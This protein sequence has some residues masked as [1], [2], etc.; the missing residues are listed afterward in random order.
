MKPFLGQ[1]LILRDEKFGCIVHDTNKGLLYVLNQTGKDILSL[2]NGKNTTNE[3]LGKMKSM[4]SCNNEAIEDLKSFIQGIIDNEIVSITVSQKNIQAS[5]V[6]GIGLNV[7]ESFE[8]NPLAHTTLSAPIIIYW[9]VTGQCNLNCVHCYNNSSAELRKAELSTQ[10][11][12]KIIDDLAKQKV[13]WLAITGGEAL[14]R[15]DIFE[16]LNYATSK[17]ICLML[18]TNGTNM[19]KE[20]A[21]A[22]KKAGVQ[23]IQVSIDGLKVIH[24]KFRGQK[25]TFSKAVKAVKLLV[26][27]KIPD[28]TVSSV[29]TK[30]NLE[31]IPK[32]I[33]LAISLKATRYRIITLM[34]AGRAQAN[35]NRLWLTTKEKLKLRRI[36]QQKS[37][38]YTGKMVISQEEGSFNLLN[39]NLHKNPIP[40]GCAAGRSI[41][42]ISPEGD[43]YPCSYFTDKNTIAG[44]LMKNSFWEIWNK[45]K[46]FKTLRTIDHI[47]GTCA[48]C[49]NLKY[50]G[51]GCR[52][53]AYNYSHNIY[54]ESPECLMVS[55]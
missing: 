39:E 14:L 52:A 2:C 50:C 49:K 16:I 9:E 53:A 36:L 5:H 10:K 40:L 32:V 51:G 7:F 12:K 45:S 19:T 1:G 20:K 8:S 24:D 17:N 33:D 23:S 27:Q 3:I 22:L 26:E 44:N 30:I 15:K 11:V 48:I 42:K 35:M 54:A 55:K 18:S 47:E 46:M 28:V 41:C 34:P 43:V 13:L 21:H 4:Y 38:E 25:G 31:E 6:A 37:K 29:A